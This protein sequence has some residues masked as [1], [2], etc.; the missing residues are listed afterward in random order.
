MRVSEREAKRVPKRVPKRGAKRDVIKKAPQQVR[1][2]ERCKNELVRLEAK[3]VRSV[4]RL[5]N[6]A[7]QDSVGRQHV[8]AGWLH[9]N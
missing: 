2:F 8:E 5:Q 4:S 7:T 3:P 6:V 9:I 1:R